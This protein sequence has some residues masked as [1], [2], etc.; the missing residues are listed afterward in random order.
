M[1][2]HTYCKHNIT[3]VRVYIQVIGVSICLSMSTNMEDTVAYRNAAF[4]G[5]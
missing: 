3:G 1:W 2:T 5:E 4:D